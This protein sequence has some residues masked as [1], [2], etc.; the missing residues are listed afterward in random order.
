MR[1]LLNRPYLI[2]AILVGI[3]L[4]F[5]TKPWAPH[6]VTDGLL[7]TGQNPASSEPAAE[8]LLAKLGRQ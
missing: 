5:V 6:V 1:A 4:F 2:A 3:V 7:I 8:A